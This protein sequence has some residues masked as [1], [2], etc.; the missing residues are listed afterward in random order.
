MV[1]S[2]QLDMQAVC[3]VSLQLHG[4]QSKPCAIKLH[5]Q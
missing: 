1:M 3:K 2:W 5:K 4:Q